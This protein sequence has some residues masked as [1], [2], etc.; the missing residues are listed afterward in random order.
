MTDQEHIFNWLTEPILQTE[1]T[2]RKIL[3]ISKIET[4]AKMPAKTLTF[5]LNG[6]RYKNITNHVHKLIPVL[7]EFGYKPMK[8]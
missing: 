8:K 4:L 7:E 1:I 6:D 2:R 3:N 5:F